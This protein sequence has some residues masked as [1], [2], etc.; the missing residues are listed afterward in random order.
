M[1]K[2]RLPSVGENTVGSYDYRVDARDD[3]ENGR[4]W[5]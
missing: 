5:D 4:V 2:A 1:M 3:G